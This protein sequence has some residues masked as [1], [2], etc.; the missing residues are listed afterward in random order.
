VVTGAY[1]DVFVAIAGAAGALTGLLFVALSVAPR[2]RA[3]QQPDVIRQIRAGAALLAF[4]NALA[5]SLFGLV[6][7]NEI[8]YPAV[9]AGVGGL[10]FT[11]G[12]VRSILADPAAR[13]RIRSQVAL[14][15]LLLGVFGFEI[16]AGINSI[17]TPHTDAPIDVIGNV[18]AASLLIGIARSWELVGDRDTGIA[19]SLAALAGHDRHLGGSVAGPADVPR[20]DAADPAGPASPTQ[21]AGARD[22]A[23]PSDPAGPRDAAGPSDAA[24]PPDPAGPVD[25]VGPVDA[26]GPHDAAGPSDPGG[27]ADHSPPD[28]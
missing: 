24:G 25:A 7:H 12:G 22:P 26:A 20:D 2:P 4:T 3:G 28:G 9:V 14:I 21:V 6:P 19:S 8:G 23:G 18:L 27:R 16:G 1:R 17:I 11:L 10:L 13:R 15:V 5:V